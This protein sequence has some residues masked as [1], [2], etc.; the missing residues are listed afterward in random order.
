M[1]KRG[2]ENSEIYLSRSSE[3]TLTAIE[4]IRK[5]TRGLTTDIIKNLGLGDAIDNICRDT[6]EINPVK[7]SYSLEILRRKA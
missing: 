4:E 3:Y 7:I 6:M 2:G 1:A 5:L